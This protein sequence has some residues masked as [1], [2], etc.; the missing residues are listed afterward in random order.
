MYSST[1]R[2]RRASAKKADSRGVWEGAADVGVEKEKFR[3]TEAAERELLRLE[4][5]DE[6]MG[7]ANSWEDIPERLIVVV[8]GMASTVEISSE[9]LIRWLWFN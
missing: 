6:N 9:K 4:A 1:E 8:S 7:E 2:H 5:D 3:D